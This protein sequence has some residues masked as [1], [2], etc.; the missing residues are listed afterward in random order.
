MCQ[1]RDFGLKSSIETVKYYGALLGW[2][3]DIL[4]PDMTMRLY[5]D[6]GM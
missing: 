5:E 1:R 6:Q 4:I 3:K 2:T